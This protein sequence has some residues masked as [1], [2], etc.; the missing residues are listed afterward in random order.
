MH[1]GGFTLMELLVA[2]TILLSVMG[3]VG[4]LFTGSMRTI[5]QGF[6]TQE[7]FEVARG[8]LS[9]IERDLS[10][11]FTSR[12]HG[13]YYNFYG[14]PI[15]MTFVG[16]VSPREGDAPNM[17]RVTY[18]IYEDPSEFFD[19][20]SPRVKTFDDE[21]RRVFSLL[22]YVETNQE[23]LES[24]PVPWDEFLSD[25]VVGVNLQSHITDALFEAQGRGDCGPEDAE[26]L[27]EVVKAK[28]RELWIRMLSGGDRPG[29][30]PNGWVV[31]DALRDLDPM[32]YAVTEDL[33][34]I[35]NEPGLEPG[36]NSLR[37]SVR[38]KGRDQRDEALF[39]PEG[40][41][42]HFFTYRAYFEEELVDP[43]PEGPQSRV[44]PVAFRY[45][46][47][48]RNMELGPGFGSP[49]DPRLPQEVT[50]HFTLF[51]E[52]AVLGAPDFERSFDQR[53]DLPTGYKRFPPL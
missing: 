27:E 42:S 39:D 1:A 22:R 30:V 7:A 18:V 44:V 32:D 12:E 26:C 15:G 35:S 24:F 20:S 31:L 3:G 43:P 17:A 48:A 25:D 41:D 37:F 16:L 2:I 13:D 28:K 21:P 50:T 34:Q 11:A 19:P 40:R 36:Q 14:T 52:S 33:L 23:D 8:A 47:D 5:R 10:R 49:L 53:I 45:W 9:I 4:L 29:Q 38:I 6:Q 51:Y 46:N